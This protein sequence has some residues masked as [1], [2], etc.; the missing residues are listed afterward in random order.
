M[1]VGIVVI[2]TNPNE[3]DHL[4]GLF[5]TMRLR[6]VFVETVDDGVDRFRAGGIDLVVVPYEQEGCGLP[7]AVRFRNSGKLQADVVLLADRLCPTLTQAARELGVL[8][9]LQRP[10][11]PRELAVAVEAHILR[12]TAV[13]DRTSRSC[14]AE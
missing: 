11:S 12:M 2:E 14:A 10:V 13:R 5:E 6:P 8:A 7:L 1:S 4:H 9:V 3:R